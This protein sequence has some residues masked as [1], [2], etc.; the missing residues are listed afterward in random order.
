MG[1]GASEGSSRNGE[2]ALL[3]FP[4][5]ETTPGEKVHAPS[6]HT[7]GNEERRPEPEKSESM[8]SN[9]GLGRRRS[10]ASSCHQYLRVL[11]PPTAVFLPEGKEGRTEAVDPKTMEDP[12]VMIHCRFTAQRLNVQTGGLSGAGVTV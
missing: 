3:Q 4:K 8:D 11:P 7:Q 12:K 10:C 5:S 9:F 6:P 2:G 1:V